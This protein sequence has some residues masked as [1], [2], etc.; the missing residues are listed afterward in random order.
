[1]STFHHILILTYR[2]WDSATVIATLTSGGALIL[3]FVVWQRFARH[4][5]IPG[6]VFAEKAS[7]RDVPKL[8]L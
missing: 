5:M 1:M 2:P 4:P 3:I 7:L 8:T 6:Y